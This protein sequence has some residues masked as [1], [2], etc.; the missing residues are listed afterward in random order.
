V[1][2]AENGHHPAWYPTEADTC[3]GCGATHSVQRI[4]GILPTVDAAMC[5]ACG[6]HWATTVVNPTLRIA[7]SIVA[8]L[9]TPQL[10]TAALLDVMRA[11]V[12]QRAQAHDPRLVTHTRWRHLT[13]CPSSRTC[14]SLSRWQRN[15]AIQ[16]AQCRSPLVRGSEGSLI[17][18]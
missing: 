18:R 15:S 9:P 5:T 13:G 1:S 14:P 7:L 4:T 16:R 11:E 17:G 12:T 2:T 8:L 10:R 3:P 6:L